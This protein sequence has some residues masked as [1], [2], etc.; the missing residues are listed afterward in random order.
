MIAMLTNLITGIGNFGGIYVG[1]V[2]LVFYSGHVWVFRH[3][4]EL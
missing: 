4:T 1:Y 3:F 2:N